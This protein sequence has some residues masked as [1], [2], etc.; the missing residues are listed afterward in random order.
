VN[1]AAAAG[2]GRLETHALAAGLQE[3]AAVVRGMSE[4]IVVLN[5]FT[6]GPQR[7]DA[8]LRKQDGGAQ[9]SAPI[10]RRGGYLGDL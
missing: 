1:V 2:Q 10:S 6:G 9:A 5:R 3:V 7:F 8:A 4:T